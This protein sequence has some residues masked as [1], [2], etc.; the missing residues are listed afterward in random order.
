MS[1]RSPNQVLAVI[2]A[3]IAVIAVVVV[4][5]SL[6]RPGANYDKNSPE[7]VVQSYLSAVFDGNYDEAENYF[8]ENSKCEASDLDRAYITKNI[9]VDL[10]D[11]D[12]TDDKARIKI[13]IEYPSG[14][15][16]DNYY[17]EEQVFRL[18]DEADQWKIAGIPWPLYDCGNLSR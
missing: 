17:T 6:N 9:R 16:L 5:I 1:K 14:A 18:V 3:L 7:G 11:T 12:I 4:V 10:L 13:Q 2:V 15:P 8:E